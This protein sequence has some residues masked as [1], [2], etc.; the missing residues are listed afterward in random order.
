[1][2]KKK[3]PHKYLLSY[4]MRINFKIINKLRNKKNNLENLIKY[5]KK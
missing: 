1:M 3:N 2:I 5:K 4:K